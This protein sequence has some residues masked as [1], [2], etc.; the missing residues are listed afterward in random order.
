MF[1]SIE[2]ERA[3]S[4]GLQSFLTQLRRCLRAR[5]TRRVQDLKDTGDIQLHNRGLYVSETK[6]LF[7]DSFTLIEEDSDL[8]Y[9]Q[10]QVTFLQDEELYKS[11]HQDVRS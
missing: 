7:G 2:K 6:N 9:L 1:L 11:K 5:K 10:I 3:D 4:R 8:E